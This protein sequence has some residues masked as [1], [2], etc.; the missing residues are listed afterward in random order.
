MS[1]LTELKGLSLITMKICS[2][3]SK[4]IKF[5]NHDFLANL[6]ARNKIIMCEEPY[7]WK[8]ANLISYKGAGHTQDL[9]QV[10]DWTYLLM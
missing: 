1:A 4:L 6:G 10:L 9:T 3:F 5:P 7:L 8:Q 2:S